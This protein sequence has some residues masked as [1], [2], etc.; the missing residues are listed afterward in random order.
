MAGASGTAARE[1]ERCVCCCSSASSCFCLFFFFPGV[2]H[3]PLALVVH[4][5]VF[6]CFFSVTVARLDK[7]S[8][9]VLS[10]S[11]GRGIRFYLY[12][13]KYYVGPSSE[14]LP[15]C[16]QVF[17]H[18]LLICTKQ[19]ISLFHFSISRFLV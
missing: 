13:K 9:G 19:E 8:A 3:S 12:L 6:S 14:V 1:T 18:A 7:T 2:P 4:G 5:A 15:L 17:M 10:P 16:L 11:C